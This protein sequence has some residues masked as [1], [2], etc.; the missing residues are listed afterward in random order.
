MPAN[1]PSSHSLLTP[2]IFSSFFPPPLIHISPNSLPFRPLFSAHLFTLHV[3]SFFILFVSHCLSFCFSLPF[4]S[5]ISSPVTDRVQREFD[6]SYKSPL[7]DGKENGH[8]QTTLLSAV[9]AA[10]YAVHKHRHQGW[11]WAE[12]RSWDPFVIITEIIPPMKVPSPYT[13]TLSFDLNN[14]NVFPVTV[15][16][17]ISINILLYLHSV[18]TCLWKCLHAALW[19]FTLIWDKEW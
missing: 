4:L 17:Y 6:F 11:D 16:T 2:T 15:N 8:T 10:S 12:A 18:W 14:R 1:H 9:L 7:H 13:P 3:P 5:F 19:V